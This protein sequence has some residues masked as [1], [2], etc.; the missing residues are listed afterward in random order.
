MAVKKFR[1]IKPEI[2]V[3]G[4]DDGVFVPR[5]KGLVPIVGVVFRGGYWLDGVMHT[6]VKIDGLDATKKITSMII[7]SPH[8][9]QLR[10]IMLNGITFAG[11]NI[12]DIRELSAETKLPV[13]AVTREKPNFKEIRE[14][15]KNL[16]KSEER[17][18]AVENAGEVHEVF[19]RNEKE[20]IYMQICGI[21]E[22]DAKKILQLTSTRSNIPEALR[23]AHLIASGITT[24]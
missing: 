19:T 13:I 22:E 4:V 20:K 23:V 12:V 6:N 16:P 24:I 11:F 2:R 8:Y 10:V 14:A 1:I 21:L 17:W 18:K 15:L 9:K 3:L 7:N 5:S